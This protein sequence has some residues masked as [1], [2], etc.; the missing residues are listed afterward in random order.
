MKCPACG[1]ESSVFNKTIKPGQLCKK[2]A[3]KAAPFMQKINEGGLLLVCEQCG[4][5][6]VLPK[7]EVTS[8][9]IL[10]V[11]KYANVNEGLLLVKTKSC[12]KEE[13]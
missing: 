9:V 2:C 1:K 8:N 6:G 13:K 5:F 12:P 4:D 7:N 10:Q 11:R 3:K